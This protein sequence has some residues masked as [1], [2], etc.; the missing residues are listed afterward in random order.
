[1]PEAWRI[2]FLGTPD[3]A[4]PSLAALAGSG[5]DVALVI[6]Q[7]DR[8][9]G[10]GRKLAPP[11][12]KVLAEELGL[13]IWQPASIKAPAQA[14][15][16][17]SLAPDL[18][19]LVAY[20]GLLPR[21]LLDVPPRGTLNV[22]PSLLPA[23]RGPAPINRAIINGDKHTGVTTILLDEGMDTGPLILSRETVI[24]ERETAGALHD[25]LARLGA[26]L[27]IESIAG[28]KAGTVSPR[29]QP[30]EGVSLAP[31][32][33]KSDGLMDWTRPAEELARLIRGLDPWPGAYTLF[34]GRYLKLFG[35][36]TGAGRGEPGRILGLHQGLL[37][38]AAGQGSVGL[39]EMQL[40]GKKRIPAPEFWRGQHLE[41]GMPIGPE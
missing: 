2:I 39:T 11:P 20:G 3:F 4:V 13:P 16:I 18:M 14:E 8:P 29:P 26:E 5:E 17:A 22:H 9:Q 1:M 34:R 37:H 28:L 6:T 23:Y 36:E 27:L 15:R 32:L 19:V 7:P 25:R 21:S 38:V 12:V 33:S 24:G 41:T 40:A 35:A 10:R 30:E 31:K